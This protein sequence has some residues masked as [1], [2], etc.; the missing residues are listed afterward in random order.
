MDVVSERATGSG[1]ARSEAEEYNPENCDGLSE[2]SDTEWDTDLEI[3]G[4]DARLLHCNP[5]VTQRL[6]LVDS[7]ARACISVEKEDYDPTG[8]KDYLRTCQ[9]LKIVPVSHFTRCL[10]AQESGV[11]L[12]HHCVGA[13]GAKAIAAA[14]TVRREGACWCSARTCLSSL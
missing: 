1:T 8:K 6:A 7:L 10:Q 5:A 2:V 11:D 4:T 12:S 3:E 13:R 9:S 14:L